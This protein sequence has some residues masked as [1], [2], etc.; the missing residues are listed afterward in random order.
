[1]SLP[2]WIR[3]LSGEP[4]T[5]TQWVVAGV[6]W[7]AVFGGMYLF[8]NVVEFQSAHFKQVRVLTLVE[9]IYL[10]SQVITTVGYGDIT[11]AYPRGQ[12]FVGFYVLSS[13]FVI[14]MLVSDM[15]SLIMSSAQRYEEKLF[16]K[17]HVE[18]NYAMKGKA[19]ANAAS[20]RKGKKKNRC[21]S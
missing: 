17:E 21:Q 9:C 18:I 3:Y 19:K 10:M 5:K 20:A 6:M 11:P 15:V 14:A 7:V 1:M 12:V 4:F 2:A 8:T 16:H 13:I